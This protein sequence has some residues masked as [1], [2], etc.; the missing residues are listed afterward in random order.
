[1]FQT[2]LIVNQILMESEEVVKNEHSFVAL[3][4]WQGRAGYTRNLT[5]APGWLSHQLSI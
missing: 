2:H 5:G 4:V 1:M 3:L